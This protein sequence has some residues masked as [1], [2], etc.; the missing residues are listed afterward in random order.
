MVNSVGWTELGGSGLDLSL[1]SLPGRENRTVAA[2]SVDQIDDS[3]ICEISIGYRAGLG[4]L[5]FVFCALYF[6]KMTLTGL[7]F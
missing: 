5:D 3:F 7:V 1:E 4:H 2:D 6:V